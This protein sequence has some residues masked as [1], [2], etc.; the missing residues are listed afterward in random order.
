MKQ[1]NAYDDDAVSEVLTRLRVHSTVYCLAELR[2]PWGFRVEG[3]D[4]AKFHLL[5]EG[6]VW[7]EVDGHDPLLLSA[8]DLVILPYGTS[9]R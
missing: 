8:G 6:D 2:S 9:T 7:L 4:V 3:R 5:L 1:L